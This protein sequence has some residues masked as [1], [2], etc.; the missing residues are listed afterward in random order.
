MT[1][2]ETPSFERSRHGVLAD[3]EVTL[4]KRFLA[5]NPW[6]GPVIPG[7]GGLRKVRWAAGGTGK[8]G[9]ARVV[10]LVMTGKERAYLLL[11]YSKSKQ[12][13]LTPAQLKVLRRLAGEVKAS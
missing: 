11:A 4:L 10:Y 8:R 12:G 6:S 2:V 7:S 3:E 5:L 1:V 13:D 9:G